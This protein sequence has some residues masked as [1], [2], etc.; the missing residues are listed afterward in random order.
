MIS[1]N[2]AAGKPSTALACHLTTF[3]TVIRIQN[4][5]VCPPAELSRREPRGCRYLWLGSCRS[6][7]CAACH[8]G[9][10]ARRISLACEVEQRWW[11]RDPSQLLPYLH[12]SWCLRPSHHPWTR[13]GMVDVR[14]AVAPR[15]NSA[16][17]SDHCPRTT[18][19]SVAWDTAAPLL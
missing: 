14:V 7:G 19:L 8:W 12:C 10:V 4:A 6:H 16:S 13:S 15:V 17:A 11:R 3:T 9:V 1:Q 5:Q 18:P 2:E